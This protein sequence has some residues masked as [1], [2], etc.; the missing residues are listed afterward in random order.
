MMLLPKILDDGRI[1]VTSSFS[2]KQL[3]GME[4]AQGVSLPTVDE[5][6]SSATVT[7]DPGEVRLVTLF[8][9][10]SVQ[11]NEGMQLLGGATSHEG[12][13]RYFAVLI[14]VN[15]YKSNSFVK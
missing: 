11:D 15:S 1:M 14:G 5:N 13:D 2:R 9:D 3:L 8:R 6:E 10:T 12:R 4:S 7:M